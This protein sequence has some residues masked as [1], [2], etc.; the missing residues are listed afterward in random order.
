MLPW[1]AA[2]SFPEIK[3]LTDKIMESQWIM[4]KH[5]KHMENMYMEKSREIHY[6]WRCLAG[7]INKLLLVDFT[8]S[9]VRL[10]GKWWM[11]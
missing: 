1:T 2:G 6:K 10:E 4:G 7:K 3:K 8:A 5:G 11:E 9:H